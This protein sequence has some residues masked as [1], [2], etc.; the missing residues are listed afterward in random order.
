MKLYNIEKFYTT[1]SSEIFAV[2]VTDIPEDECTFFQTYDQA[3]EAIL[4]STKIDVENER[5][6][7]EIGRA[8]V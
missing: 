8:H 5:R 2:R 7:T 3:F 4:K 6:P 1:D